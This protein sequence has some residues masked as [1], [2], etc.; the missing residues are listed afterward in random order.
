MRACPRCSRLVSIAD[1]R[2]YDYRAGWLC[3]H[4][5]VSRD[6][7]VGGDALRHAELEVEWRLP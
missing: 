5:E 6:K 1:L 7:I 2:L 4:C 3:T